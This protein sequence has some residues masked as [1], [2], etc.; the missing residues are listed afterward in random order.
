MEQV[1]Q[2]QSHEGELGYKVLPTIVKSALI[3]GQTNAESERSLS[4]NTKVVTKERAS[5]NERTIVGLHVVK[6]AVRFFD[7]VSNQPEKIIITDDMR[8][9]VKSAHA[10]YRERL[11][12]EKRRGRRKEERS[13]EK[14][15]DL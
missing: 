14:E 4:V 2:L 1:F 6:E 13:S 15:I 11:E 12:R 8:R 5:L 7:P 9:S 3:L 10:M